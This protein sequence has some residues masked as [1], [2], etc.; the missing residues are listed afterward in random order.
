MTGYNYFNNT[1]WS[2]PSSN[3][4]LVLSNNFTNSNHEIDFINNNKSAVN[5]VNFYQMNS[6]GTGVNEIAFIDASGNICGNDFVLMSGGSIST[7]YSKLA[8]NN[9]FTGSNT[10]NAITINSGYNLNLNGNLYVNSTSISPT[11]LS[12]L[13]GLSSNAQ[14]YL[15]NLSN[16]FA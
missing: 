11:I 1:Y 7:I 14:T 10:F 6:S 16:N 8:T 13:S 2:L 5:C 3:S 4:G 9:N 12:Y 15:T